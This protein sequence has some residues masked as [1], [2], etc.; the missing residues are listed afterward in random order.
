VLAHLADVVCTLARAREL[1]GRLA[2]NADLDAVTT[3]WRA[4]IEHDRTIG[5]AYLHQLVSKVVVY[6]NEIVIE[7]RSASVGVVR[8]PN[9]NAPLG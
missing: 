1:A 8:S 4:L 6:E 5:R 3:T 7:P 9:E 2:M